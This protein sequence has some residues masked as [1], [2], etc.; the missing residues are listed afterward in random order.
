MQRVHL[1]RIHNYVM[2]IRELQ[3]EVGGF[4][5]QQRNVMREYSSK[6]VKDLGEFISQERRK[7]SMQYL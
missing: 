1:M 5:E 7:V 2:E 6:I 3:G 4:V